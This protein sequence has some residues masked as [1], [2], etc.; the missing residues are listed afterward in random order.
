MF[1]CKNKILYI[2]IDEGGNLDFT[3]N[4]TKYYIL[5][6]VSKYRPFKAF[7]KLNNLKYDII[8]DDNDFECFHASEDRQAVRNEVFKII[9]KYFSDS[10][11]DSLIVEKSKIDFENQEVIKFYSVQFGQLII[12][13]TN[14]I[15]CNN[16]NKIIIFT[17]SIPLK[18]KAKAIEKSI[19]I[20]LATALK[21]KVKYQIHHHQ[22]KS[23]FD[24]QL[25]DYCNWAIYRRWESGDNRSY[26][27]IKK[28]IRSETL[29]E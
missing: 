12:E 29:V 10:K 5:T 7:R 23:N 25:A 6:S 11:I 17:D 14:R 28:Y 15:D 19:K 20:E 21:G 9:N 2:F 22:S 16:L 1:N 3:S 8:E 18:K 26:D 24:L 13:L 27:L 4:G